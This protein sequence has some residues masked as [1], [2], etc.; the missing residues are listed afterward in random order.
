MKSNLRNQVQLPHRVEIR[1]TDSDRAL[2]DSLRE[3]YGTDTQSIR[4]A[5]RRLA[6]EK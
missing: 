2:L 6:K 4:T 5:I 1:L 3:D